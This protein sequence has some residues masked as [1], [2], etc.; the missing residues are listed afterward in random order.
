MNRT[1]LELLMLALLF[2]PSAEAAARARSAALSGL[3]NLN[4]ATAEQLDLLPGVGPK[5]AS[6]IIAYRQKRAFE[7]IE[8][9]VQVK[10]FG[11]RRFE[12]MR[13]HLAIRGVTTLRRSEPRAPAATHR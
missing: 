6:Q 7:R 12:R 5:A 8:E 2:S 13:S 11:K 3:L 9:L 4:G 10:G 1:T